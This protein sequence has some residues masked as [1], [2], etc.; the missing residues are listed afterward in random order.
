[1]SDEIIIL[2]A[3]D[4]PH[5]FAVAEGIRRKGGQVTIWY[6]G[7]FPISS[8]ATIEFDGDRMNLE[9][10]GAHQSVI[11]AQPRTVWN[12]RVSKTIDVS[13]LHPADQT[14]GFGQCL[15]LRRSTVDLLGE[16]SFWVN[17]PQAQ[18]RA[19][20]KPVQMREAQKAGFEV[21]R[22]IYSNDRAQI[23]AFLRAMGGRV[24]FKQMAL[25]GIWS[26]GGKRFAP[27][28]T[29]ITE[30]QLPDDLRTAAAP[31]IFQEVLSRAYE[32]RVTMIGERMFVT[33]LDPPH[34]DDARIDWRLAVLRGQTSRM[35][36]GHLPERTEQSIRSYMNAM[37]LVFGCFDLI[38]T[39][40][41]RHVFIEC[42]EAGQ[43]LFVEEETGE[44]VLDA[45]VAFLMQGRPDFEWSETADSLRLSEIWQIARE[46]SRLA[47]SVH[48]VTPPTRF[49]ETAD[50]DAVTDKVRDPGN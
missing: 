36:Q 33:R 40:E 41:G 49:Q 14:F 5:A 22:T 13:A 35:T 16:R 8:W 38:V 29:V 24:V 19:I 1:M 6:T 47:Q 31:G 45:F 26:D 28:T 32:L 17:A 18:A 20:L 34:T 2:S 11:G 25:V 3:V 37:G 30:E 10:R 23:L 27:Y 43:F 50:E 15:D 7:D 48:T 4:D 44:A 46:Q 42:N 21:P 9:I 12:R 39:P